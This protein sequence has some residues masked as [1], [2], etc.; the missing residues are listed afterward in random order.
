MIENEIM[1][2]TDFLK[3]AVLALLPGLGVAAVSVTNPQ[4]SGPISGGDHGFAF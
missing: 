1:N 3:F 2:R 4:W